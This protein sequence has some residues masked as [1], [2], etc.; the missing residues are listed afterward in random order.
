[1]IEELAQHTQL[2][3]KTTENLS[4]NPQLI[5]ACGFAWLAQQRL[6]L[7]RLNYQKITGSRKNHLL[8]V[9]VHP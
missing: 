5:E 3:I 1:L 2:K 7:K 9:I 6:S 8:G 4:I